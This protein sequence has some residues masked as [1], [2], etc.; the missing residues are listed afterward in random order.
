MSNRFRVIPWRN[1]PP[2]GAVSEG[3]NSPPSARCNVR[4]GARFHRFS[5]SSSN[6]SI[7][8]ATLCCKDYQEEAVRLFIRN[9]VVVS[10]GANSSWFLTTAK[11]YVKLSCHSSVCYC[12][13]FPRQ[14]ILKLTG[15]VQDRIALWTSESKTV[16]LV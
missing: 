16:I 13:E 2:E 12:G 14:L 1:R 7:A 4:Y 3:V 10:L 15:D 11:D 6:F 8:T 5:Y 9:S